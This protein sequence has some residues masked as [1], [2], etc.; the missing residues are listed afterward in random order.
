[1]TLRYSRWLPRDMVPDAVPEVEAHVREHLSAVADPNDEP[2]RADEVEI[3]HE[4]AEDERG[5]DGVLVIG[6]LDAEPDA[7]YLRPGFTPEQDIAANPLTV[8]SI[9]EQP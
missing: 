9:E 2:T 8:E 6:E 5:V 3:S 1:V 7:P 4:D